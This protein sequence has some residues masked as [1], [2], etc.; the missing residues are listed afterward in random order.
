M[1][2]KLVTLAARTYVEVVR[3]VS[4]LA[5]RTQVVVVEDVSTISIKI[6]HGVS[7]GKDATVIL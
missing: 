3:D 1:L 5:S 6:V 2:E 4:N 7:W